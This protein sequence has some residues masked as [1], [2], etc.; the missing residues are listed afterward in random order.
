LFSIVSALFAK[1]HPGWGQGAILLNNPRSA[2]CLAASV[3]DLFQRITGHGTRVTSHESRVTSHHLF[4]SAPLHLPPTAGVLEFE[5][6]PHD[7]CQFT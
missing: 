2:L 4:L 5:W 6:K 1:N 7:N 3:A